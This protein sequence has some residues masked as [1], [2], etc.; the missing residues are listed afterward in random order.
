MPLIPVGLRAMSVALGLLAMAEISPARAQTPPPLIA[1]AADLQFAAADIAQQFRNDTVQEVRLSFGSS[2]I[3]TR[4]IEQ[5][6]PVEMFLSA[7]EAFVFRLTEGGHT[8]GFS[9]P[10]HAALRNGRAVGEDCTVSPVREAIHLM[11]QP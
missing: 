8:P 7:D 9:M 1:G 3:I 10:L 2:G 11:P 4:Q 6:S 5:G